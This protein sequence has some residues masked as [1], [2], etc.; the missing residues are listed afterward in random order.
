MCSKRRVTAA[1]G[2][3]EAVHGAVARVCARRRVEEPWGGVG[4]VVR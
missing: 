1:R 4:C 2:V 3:C